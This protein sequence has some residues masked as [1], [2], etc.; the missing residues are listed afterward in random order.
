MTDINFNAEEIA[1][2]K[3]GL[4]KYVDSKVTGATPCPLSYVDES[5]AAAQILMPQY[6]LGIALAVDGLT[7]A[8][9]FDLHGFPVKAVRTHRRGNGAIWSPID[10]LSQEDIENKRVL[11]FDNDVVTGRT[12]RKAGN[13]LHKFSP[14]YLDLL[15]MHEMTFVSA[16]HYKSWRK[17][18]NLPT[19]QE[20]YPH[21]NILDTRETL[22][23]LEIDYIPFDDIQQRWNI[24]TMKKQNEE[25][26]V[27][28][29]T[30]ERVKLVMD[31]RKGFRKVMTLENDFKYC[32]YDFERARKLVESI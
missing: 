26:F 2:L 9:F 6:D 8:Y 20:I 25:L 1:R 22:E 16:R 17:N 11:L 14:R 31:S 5:F 7:P 12:I 18:Y 27:G 3:Q 29:N 24:R 10:S 4:A 30:K 15:L 19:P 21:L 13:E 28:L 32:P 23:G